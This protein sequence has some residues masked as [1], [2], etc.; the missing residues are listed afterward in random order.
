MEGVDRPATVVAGLDSERHQDTPFQVALA[1]R[2][3]SRSHVDVIRF[4]HVGHAIANGGSDDK[5]GRLR[6]LESEF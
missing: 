1:G 3:I 2:R 5:I 6:S 4:D